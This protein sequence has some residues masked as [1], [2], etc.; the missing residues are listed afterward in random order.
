M[1]AQ[2]L[3]LSYYSSMRNER[4]NE[5]K[6]TT[7]SIYE[8]NKN[9][10]KAEAGQSLSRLHSPHQTAEDIVKI[11]AFVVMA[12]NEDMVKDALVACEDAGVIRRFED[13]EFEILQDFTTRRLRMMKVFC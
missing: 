12:E 13:W 10:I 6:E 4:N 11:K 1:L 7:M 9:A 3:A 5:R 8:T 2:P